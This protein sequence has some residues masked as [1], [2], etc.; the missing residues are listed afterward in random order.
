ME[1]SDSQPIE[2]SSLG[3]EMLGEESSVPTQDNSELVAIVA[4]VRD[5]QYQTDAFVAAGMGFIAALLV[6]LVI[7]VMWHKG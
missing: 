2:E 6:V 3:G 4:Q 5:Q 7:A 1:P